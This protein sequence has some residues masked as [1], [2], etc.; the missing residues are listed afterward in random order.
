MVRAPPRP[1]TETHHEFEKRLIMAEQIKVHDLGEDTDLWIVTGTTDAHSAD[2]AVRQRVE[3]LT[4]ET[5][6]ALQ[7]A[8]DLVEF[9]FQ[10]R[11][12]WAWLPGGNPADPMD[13]AALVHG[14]TSASIQRILPTFPGILVAA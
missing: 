9:T 8:D 13:E 5:I 3:D 11:K 14:G 6:E 4:G 7:D 10:N 2:E 1:S 12:D